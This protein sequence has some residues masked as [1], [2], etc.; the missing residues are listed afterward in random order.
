MYAHSED[1]IR[2]ECQ[3]FTQKDIEI[4]RKYYEMQDK[5]TDWKAKHSENRKKAKVSESQA[6]GDKNGSS[7]NPTTWPA[8]PPDFDAILQK[9]EPNQ[10]PP[11]QADQMM[12]QNELN[13]PNRMKS[14][15]QHNICSNNGQYVPNMDKNAGQMSESSQSYSPEHQSNSE[16]DFSSM[17]NSITGQSGMNS[18]VNNTIPNIDPMLM[19]SLLQLPMALNTKV[20]LLKTGEELEEVR[21][22][23]R[24]V[25]KLIKKRKFIEASEIMLFLTHNKYIEYVYNDQNLCGLSYIMSYLS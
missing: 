3:Q 5:K 7:D 6:G 18:T 12:P 19:I 13:S 17:S 10:S 1:K 21:R 25:K 11:S 22:V 16:Q 2:I 20:R 24:M 8:T 15:D 14:E 9:Q 23:M 4:I